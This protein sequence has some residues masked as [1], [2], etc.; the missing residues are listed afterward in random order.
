MESGEAGNGTQETILSFLRSGGLTLSDTWSILL[1]SDGTDRLDSRPGDAKMFLTSINTA[2]NQTLH[3]SVGQVYYFGAS[4]SPSRIIVTFADSKIVRYRAYPYKTDQ[5]IDIRIFRD[6]T[7]SGCNTWLKSGYV[8]Y[9]PETAA[10]LRGLLDGVAGPVY[11]AE[12][13]QPVYV[14]VRCEDA[15]I[16]DPWSD[17]EEK[18]VPHAVS[19]ERDGVLEIS[20]IRGEVDEL[21]AMLAG[22]AYVVEGVVER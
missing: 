15:A 9:H 16:S 18:F 10:H 21:R 22:S 2:A 19:A 6:L 1:L 20:W 5:T 14:L 7:V 13:L 4:S 3:I 17:I 11:T 12:D 8:Q